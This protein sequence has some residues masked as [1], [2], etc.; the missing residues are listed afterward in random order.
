MKTQYF[1]SNY[2]FRRRIK[3]SHKVLI[4]DDEAAIRETI[5]D[6][7][8]DHN[9]NTLVAGDGESAEKKLLTEDLDVLILDVM[10]PNKGGLELLDLIHVEYPL[11]PTIIISGHGNIRMAVDAMKRGAFDFIEKP[12][13][14]ERILNSV[15]NAIRIRELQTENIN[16]RSRLEKPPVFVGESPVIKTILNQVSNIAETDASVL[17]T[18]ENGTGK[19]MIA[20]LIHLGGPRKFHNFVG[21]NCAAIPETL[22]ESELFG[23]EKGAFTGAHK[24]KKGKFE[25][26][27]KGTVFLDEI[28]DLSLPAQAKVLRVL[29]EK[30]LQR[31]GGNETIHV[32]VR[33]LSATNKDLSKEIEAGRFREDLFYRLNVIPLHLPP[34]RERKED[35]PLL[36]SHFTQEISEKNGKKVSFTKA[37]LSLLANKSWA[38]N[39]RELRNFIE[40]L[41]I[42]STSEEIGKD[43]I[44]RFSAPSQSME[45][46]FES[47]NLKD[48]KREFEK[49]LI[50]NRLLKHNMN[51]T[52]T[53]ESLEIERTYLHKKIKELGIDSELNLGKN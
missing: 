45:A 42:L 33:I 41:I 26:A 6:I 2:P 34:L 22:I 43:D 14:I 49:G 4:V 37:A 44:L 13:S 52:K 19:E 17:I 47:R 50:I 32:D 8:K 18:G 12:L 25:A 36:V 11:L 15:K 20:R 35:I 9:Y 30:E 38:G 23:H 3:V 7:L 39:V 46:R 5:E 48:A 27:D 29:Q 53:A 40:R 31:V 21:V 28:G 1:I 24:Q 10:L 51:I 16:L